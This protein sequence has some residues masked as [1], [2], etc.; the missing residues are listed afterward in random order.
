V[1]SALSGKKGVCQSR[2]EGRDPMYIGV[3]TV[4]LILLIIVLIAFVF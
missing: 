2:Y 1:R 3:G 4:L